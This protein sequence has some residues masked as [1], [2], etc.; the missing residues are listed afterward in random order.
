[1]RPSAILRDF[2]LAI[3]NAITENFAAGVGNYGDLFHF[4]RDNRKWM[5]V[6]RI[7]PE[8]INSICNDLHLLAVSATLERFRAQLDAFKNRWSELEPDYIAY[9]STQWLSNVQYGEWAM[10]ARPSGTPS[11]D[12]QLESWHHHFHGTVLQ[13]RSHLALDTFIGLLADEWL[14][15]AALLASPQLLKQHVADINANRAR[16]GA[17][18]TPRV[19]PRS[20]PPSPPAPEP[21]FACSASATCTGHRGA[22]SRSCT[23]R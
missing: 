6:R 5:H 22:C 7:D 19:E 10:Y 2:D 11:G 4:L 16:H 8:H 20:Q 18:I 15:V 17:C 14:K 9:F 3:R 23:A 21:L 1:M 12:Q 13:G